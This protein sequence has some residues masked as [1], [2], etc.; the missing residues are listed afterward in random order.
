MLSPFTSYTLRIAASNGAGTGQESN[1]TFQTDV[2]SMF[3]C[4]YLKT[5]LFKDNQ[6]VNY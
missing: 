5:N 1:I 2:G 3:I 6:C 4:I